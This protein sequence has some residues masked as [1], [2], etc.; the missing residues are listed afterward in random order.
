[1]AWAIP[2]MR[3]TPPRSA[4]RRVMGFRA[5]RP[6]PREQGPIR[7]TAR[8]AQRRSRE[9]SNADPGP[10]R[11]R[12]GEGM[13]FY[14]KAP[15]RKLLLALPL[16]LG[17]PLVRPSN[18]IPGVITVLTRTTDSLI[19]QGLTSS[20]GTLN[21]SY[22]GVSCRIQWLG[23]PL[24]VKNDTV[25]SAAPTADTL[26]WHSL[27]AGTKVRFRLRACAGSSCSSTKTTTFIVPT[28]GTGTPVGAT[29]TS[30]AIHPTPP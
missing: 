3:R 23:G 28:S 25:P 24:V 10:D 19:V 8:K 13:N 9:A 29:L 15:M 4:P 11:R 21:G 7:S 27:A 14:K 17:L 30:L 26:R 20:C 16:F 22:T 12:L 6:K 18:P 5:A 2:T 1:M